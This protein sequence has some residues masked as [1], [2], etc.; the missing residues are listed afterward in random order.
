MNTSGKRHNLNRNFW[1]IRH[2]N[3]LFNLSL[4]QV[5][6]ADEPTNYGFVHNEK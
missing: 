6:V 5:F 4:T 1:S 2:A 3:E